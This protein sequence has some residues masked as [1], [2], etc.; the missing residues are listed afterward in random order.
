[1]EKLLSIVKQHWGYDTLWPLQEHAMRSAMDNRDSLVVLPTGGGKSLCF[2]AP[3]IAMDGM[4]IVISPLISLMKDQVDSLEM[5]GINAACINSSLTP[6]ERHGVDE[7]IRTG[8]LKLLYVAPERMVMPNFIEYLKHT[9]LSFLAIDEAHCISHWG[10][11]FRPEYRELGKLRTEFP[12]LPIHAYTATATEHVRE[13][14]CKELNLKD[15]NVLI[16]SFD[17]PNLVYRATRRNDRFQ[18]VRGV[19]DKHRSESGIVY[20]IT[21][22]NVDE[23]CDKLCHAGYA[24]LPY[25]AGMSSLER[26]HNQEAFAREKC[27]IIV[28]TVA[29]GMGIDKSN[30]RYVVHAG[31]PKSLEHYQQ[32]SGR[33]GRDG[34]EAECHMFYSGADFA[35]WRHIMG[36]SEGEAAEIALSKLKDIESYCTGVT[37]R[38]KA[39]ISYFGQDLDKENCAACDL[40]LGD[41]ELV[42]DALTKAQKILSC[43]VRLDKIAGPSYTSLIL[44][45]SKEARVLEKQHDQLSTWGIMAE[46]DKN[47]IRDWIEQLVAQGHLEKQGEYNILNV[48]D[49]GRQLLRGEDTP[50]LLKA[51]EKAKK[52]KKS[53]AETK[54][55]KGVDRDLFEELR[56]K[57]FELAQERA[58]PA[59]V[60]FGDATLRDMARL[61]PATEMEFLQ[62]RGVGEK[63]CKTF[64]N[65]FLPIIR[66]NLEAKGFDSEQAPLQTAYNFKTAPEK[67]SKDRQKAKREAFALFEQGYNAG[68]VAPRIGR[69]VLTTQGYLTDYVT[70]NGITDPSPW[71]DDATF[72]RIREAV[73]TLG[74]SKLK[75]ISQFLDDQVEYDDIHIAVACLRNM[76]TQ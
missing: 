18:Q 53:A 59:F 76:D 8:S 31:M 5:Y 74:D 71:M 28:A 54:S 21:R 51:A 56:S 55:W 62:V 20:C 24:A 1:M 50:R 4:A 63:K 40:C 64:A 57:R 65:D 67:K 7:A 45:G 6:Q 38:H 36:N 69:A 14:I 37:C 32:E 58:V 27:D 22:K 13:D 26:K 17:R 19:I 39:I 44:S 68:Q 29:F 47:A 70:E 35:T 2:Q 52:R 48:T 66:E 43:V 46:H 25:H 72:E 11:D 75:S 12:N 33:A 60:I 15:P 42:E 9:P 34:L 16:G 23:L 30:V 73:Q 10:H 3:A 49:K 41:A 61:K